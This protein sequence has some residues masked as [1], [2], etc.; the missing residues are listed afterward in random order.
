MAKRILVIDDDELLLFVW[1]HALKK[2]ENEYE[3][4]TTS[5]GYEALRRIREE[6]FDLVVTDLLMPDVNGYELTEAIRDL[7]PDMPVI[8]LSGSSEKKVLAEAERLRVNRRLD[9]P[10]S[11]SEI[12]DAVVEAL[13]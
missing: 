3:I 5:D 11:A 6:H 12:R 1:N 9:K 10:L 7:H 4:E 8:W 13:G 2:I